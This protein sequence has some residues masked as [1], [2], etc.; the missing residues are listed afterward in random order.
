MA[1][2]TTTGITIK[3]VSEILTDIEAE[4]IANIDADLN[5]EA[6]EILGQL[7]GVYAAALAELW[8]LLEEIYQSAYP[9]TASGQSLSYVAALTGAIRQVATKAE[10]KVRLTGTVS[11]LVPAGTQFY[12]DGDPDSLFELTADATILEQGT[13]DYVDVTAYAV[14]E[15]SATTYAVGT[16][17]LVIATPV[18]GLTS[19]AEIGAAPRFTAGVDEETDSELRLRREQSLALAGASTV[20]AI[21][22]DMLTVAGVD[23]CTVF[24]NPTGQTDAQGLPPNSIE[25]LVD[26]TAAPT[27]VEADVVQQIWDSKPAGTETYGGLGAYATDSQGNQQSILYSTPS[28]VRLYVDITLTAATDGS[29]LGDSEVGN[30]VEDWATANLRV[31]QSVYASDIINVVADLAGVVSVSPSSVLVDNLST[32]VSTDWAATARQLGTIDNRVNGDVTV[33]SV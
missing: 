18:S 12:V 28:T 1:G 2:L 7:N 33:T 10:L 32:P 9:D 5:V 16:D 11:T 31:G 4:Q 13:P 17:T 29:Y 6:D 26:S 24:E 3:D 30:A 14:T 21:R 25:V 15:G 22:A 19:V 23:T 27:Y 8:E 20:E